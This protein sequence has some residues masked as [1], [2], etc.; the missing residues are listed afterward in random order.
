[1]KHG[2]LSD[3]TTEQWIWVCLKMAYTLHIANLVG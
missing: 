1:M 2:D 3:L